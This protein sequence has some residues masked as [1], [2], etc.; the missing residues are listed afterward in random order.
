MDHGYLSTSFELSEGNIYSPKDSRHGNFDQEVE[1]G[2]SRNHMDFGT[3]LVMG[4]NVVF[5]PE[6]LLQ[7]LLGMVTS[8]HVIIIVFVAIITTIIIIATA[9]VAVVAFVS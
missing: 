5:V 9:T 6:L 1:S 2:S 4:S 7:L 3:K 8:K